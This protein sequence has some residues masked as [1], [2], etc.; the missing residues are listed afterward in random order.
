MPIPKN[1]ESKQ[2]N[3]IGFSGNQ[4]FRV[5]LC[6]KQLLPPLPSGRK[7]EHTEEE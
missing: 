4:T 5:R 1:V 7:D 6:G 2:G 3:V